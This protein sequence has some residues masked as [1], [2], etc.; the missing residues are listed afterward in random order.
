MSDDF[1]QQQILDGAYTAMCGQ[2]TICAAL[3]RKCA[4]FRVL[5]EIAVNESKFAVF[6]LQV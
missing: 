5:Q 1:G 4:A 3:L 6:K 2:A